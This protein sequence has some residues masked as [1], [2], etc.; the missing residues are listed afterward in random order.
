MYMDLHR[1]HFVCINEAYMG[2]TH[3]LWCLRHQH[4]Y[5]CVYINSKVHI[6]IHHKFQHY[7]EIALYTRVYTYTTQYTIIH[8]RNIEKLP[9]QNYIGMI[10]RSLQIAKYYFI[11]I[12]LF[13][14]HNLL[15][16]QMYYLCGY[17]T[18]WPLSYNNERDA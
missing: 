13:T 9:T 16:N 18:A 5:I 10:C 17:I 7:L 2:C 3:A 4:A 8:S 15:Y 1:Q 6:H 14:I 11:I 12:L